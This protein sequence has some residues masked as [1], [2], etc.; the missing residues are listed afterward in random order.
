MAEL[1]IDYRSTLCF[2]TRGRYEYSVKSSV[3]MPWLDCDG[4]FA[5]SG[6]TLLRSRLMALKR[7][8]QFE[9]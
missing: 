2:F 3:T 6:D 1:L 8:S 9:A 7:S 5:E 4:G